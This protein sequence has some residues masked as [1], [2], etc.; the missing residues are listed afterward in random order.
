MKTTI[1]RKDGAAVLDTA[2]AANRAGWAWVGL[3]ASLVLIIIGAAAYATIMRQGPLF[4]NY[5]SYVSW[6]L[7]KSWY[8]YLVWLEAGTL[9]TYSILANIM[10]NAQLK[11]IAPLVYLSGLM[12]L[13]AAVIT[14]FTDLG[15]IMD[16]GRLKNILNIFLRPNFSSMITWMVWMH[17]LYSAIVGAQLV[18]SIMEKK[19]MKAA[20]RL[21]TASGVL[22]VIAG[23][24]LVGIISAVFT[25]MSGF[26]AWKWGSLPIMFL[27]SSLVV[28]SAVLTLL[29]TVLSPDRHAPV[30]RATLQMLGRTTLMVITTAAIA[31]IGSAALQKTTAV[32]VYFSG[33]SNS[34][35]A[36]AA[37]LAAPIILI[38][39]LTQSAIQGPKERLVAGLAAALMLI[40]LRV[41]PYNIII[42][43]QMSEPLPGLESAFLHERLS[44]VYS[45]SV[46]EIAINA[47]PLG[48]ALLGF[49]AGYWILHSISPLKP[50]VEEA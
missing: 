14:V 27:L 49:V 16:T 30:H 31:G 17:V 21:S 1:S 3:A 12:L 7:V 15:I 37:G 33:A 13:I 18:V 24:A 5:T 45:P 40:S 36:I 35:W 26:S 42:N 19:G 39:L 25:A 44:Y 32:A 46:A 6:G 41:I 4:A 10:K 43:P 8:V 47:L 50:A 9:I 38:L 48:I 11:A 34:G 23:V 20:A 2:I 22:S 28:G 29:Y